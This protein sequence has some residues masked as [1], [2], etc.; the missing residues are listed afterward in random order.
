MICLLEH[1]IESSNHPEQCR[2]SQEHIGPEK[3]FSQ[4]DTG[5]IGFIDAML[6]GV[7]LRIQ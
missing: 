7:N 6:G 3:L 1:P 4:K 2:L 5:N